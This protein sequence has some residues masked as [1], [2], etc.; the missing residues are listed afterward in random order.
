VP[1]WLRIRTK[2][3]AS[4]RVRVQP[5]IFCIRRTIRMSTFGQTVREGDLG[6]SREGKHLLLPVQEAPI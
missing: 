6:I 2:R 5:E 1:I 3:E 4:S